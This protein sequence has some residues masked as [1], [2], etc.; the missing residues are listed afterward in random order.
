METSWGKRVLQYFAYNTFDAELHESFSHLYGGNIE[1]HIKRLY[2][3]PYP[4]RYLATFVGLLTANRGH[5]MV[6]NI[7]ED[8]LSD[9]FQQHI[10]KYRQSWEKP[11]F[12]L[13]LRILAVPGCAGKP[14]QSI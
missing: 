11:Y 8:C 9:F 12:F 3:Q 2:Q 1:T 10:L 4:N 14:L 6:E 5:Y 7:I 13:G